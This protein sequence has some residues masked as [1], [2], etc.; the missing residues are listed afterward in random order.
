M[1]IEFQNTPQD[2]REAAELIAAS[3]AG[4]RLDEPLTAA[5]FLRSIGS[6]GATAFIA[7][8]WISMQ[9]VPMLI[10]GAPK[11]EPLAFLHLFMPFFVVTAIA[12]VARVW[13]SGADA[14]ARRTPLRWYRRTIVPIA[15][16]LALLALL[17]LLRRY[18]FGGLDDVTPEPLIPWPLVWNFIFPHVGWIATTVGWHIDHARASRRWVDHAWEQDAELSEPRILEANDSF[19]RITTPE[20]RTE[21]DWHVFR[22]F[23]ETPNLFL[24]PI[25]D[26][27]LHVIPRRA[28]PDAD[29]E[30]HFRDLLVRN[31][32]QRPVAFPV[33][34]TD[35]PPRPE[36]EPED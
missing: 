3:S 6:Y 11:P 32:T 28:F 31:I 2:L 21:H 19:V 26:R 7:L 23:F 10:P 12:V 33:V 25:S 8:V 34:P 16:V 17:L 13:R 4:A 1:R 24:M 27:Y 18:A 5:H 35:L 15:A 14:I 36:T 22:R 9:V 30:S 20:A 29:L